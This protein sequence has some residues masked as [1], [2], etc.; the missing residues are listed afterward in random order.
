MD[1][2]SLSALNRGSAVDPLIVQCGHCL[3]TGQCLRSHSGRYSCDSCCR[4]AG[5]SNAWSAKLVR[6]GV[7]GGVGKVRIRNQ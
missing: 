6:C 2:D 3:G 7:C 4:D 5:V 1:R